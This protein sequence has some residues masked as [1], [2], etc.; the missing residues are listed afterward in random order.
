MVKNIT[1]SPSVIIMSCPSMLPTLSIRKSCIAGAFFRSSSCTLNS[2]PVI[3]AANSSI[4][5]KLIVS[6]AV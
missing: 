4:C 1:K 2:S 3:L 6:T 5:S